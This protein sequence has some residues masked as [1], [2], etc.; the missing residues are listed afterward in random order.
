[1]IT[2]INP[3]DQPI[4]T[5][6]S[7]QKQE[8]NVLPPLS[9]TQ[10]QAT[11]DST[12]L[13]YLHPAPGAAAPP[14]PLS[15]IPAPFSGASV[16]NYSAGPE[17]TSVSK[18]KLVS[19]FLLGFLLNFLFLIPTILWLAFKS[20]NGTKKKFLAYIIGII[21]SFVIALLLSGILT[22]FFTQKLTEAI[23]SLGY[24]PQRLS[25]VYPD[26][27][28]GASAYF[29][30]EISNGTDVS[31][32]TL[33]VTATSTE[34]LDPETVKQIGIL[35]CDALADHNE[36]FDR[37]TISQT[38]IK[39]FLFL[40][41]NTYITADQTCLEWYGGDAPVMLDFPALD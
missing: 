29:Q 25:A 37:V 33:T 40:K 34:P 31:T 22:P 26:V 12:L 20:K 1:M 36:S 10:N 30:K 8:L 14:N 6:D 15:P 21:G 24:V 39:K 4:P 28:F 3:I 41:L 5:D 23:P 17:D 13:A 19:Y 9:Q 38:K 32:S 7:L 16:P 11:Q 27:N 35:T 18:K 2:A